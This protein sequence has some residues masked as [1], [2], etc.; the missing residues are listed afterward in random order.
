MQ[1]VAQ[2]LAG[3]GSVLVLTHQKPDGDAL[4]STLALARAMQRINP[5][6]FGG[7]PA[8]RDVLLALCGSMPVWAESVIGGTRWVRE[9]VPGDWHSPEVVVVLD[10]GSVQ[11]LGVLGSVATRAADRVIV[12]DHHVQ[13]DAD[14]FARRVVDTK[15]AAVCELVAELC[16]RLLGVERCAQLPADVAQ[17]L[18]LGLATDTGW[19]KFSNVRPGTLRLAAEL[20]E[21]GVD[22]AQLFALVEQ[23]DRLERYR[24]LGRALGSMRVVEGGSVAVQELTR[25]D[26]RASGASEAETEGFSA[27]PLDIAGVRVSVLMCESTDA[28]GVGIVKVSL[29]SRPQAKDGSGPAAVDVSSVAAELGGG[30]HARAA[31]ARLAGTI[32]SVRER[33]MGAVLGSVR[34]SASAGTDRSAPSGAVRP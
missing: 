32:A 7:A 14:V 30:G 18:Y 11:Q 28:D 23:Q 15:A 17:P 33:V 27:T 16:C 22:H 5:G 1:R 31:G 19:F 8:H 10:T 6:L 34:A 21:A 26:F 20:I 4:G 25:E 24:L 9:A 13:G 2:T 3:A 12:I 29:R